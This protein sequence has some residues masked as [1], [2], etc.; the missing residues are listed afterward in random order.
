MSGCSFRGDEWQ[1]GGVHPG[2]ETL[3]HAPDQK[4]VHTLLDRLLLDRPEGCNLD[5][6]AG[7]VVAAVNMVLRLGGGFTYVAECGWI[8]LRGN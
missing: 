6:A 7:R 8:F 5:F 4:E 2:V 1:R 3:E